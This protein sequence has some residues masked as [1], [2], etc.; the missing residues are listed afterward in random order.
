MLKQGSRL[1]P[2][3]SFLRA[4][5]LS[6][7]LTVAYVLAVAMASEFLAREDLPSISEFLLGVVIWFVGVAACL[8]PVAVCVHFIGKRIKGSFV[9]VWIGLAGALGLLGMFLWAY[10]FGGELPGLDMNSFLL[11]S[12]A[13]L[14]SCLFAHFD[15]R[16][17]REAS[18]CAVGS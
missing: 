13:L 16:N 11:G 9:V 7:I 15:R 18:G 17:G 5:L 12:G 10:S 2:F 3:L 1:K 6:A 14:A 8:L 4:W